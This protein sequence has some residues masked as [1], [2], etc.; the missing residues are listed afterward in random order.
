MGAVIAFHAFPKTLPGGFLGVD[1]FFVI[2]GFLISGMIL[3]AIRE[4]RFS[5][6]DFY[7][8]RARRIVPALLTMLSCITLLAA[9]VLMPDEMERFG[10]N[11]T[12]GALFVP[13]LVLAREQ[14]YFDPAAIDNPLLHLWS[15]GVEEQ[16]YL[17]WP[18]ALMLLLPRM[19]AR[20]MVFVIAAIIVLSFAL[21]AVMA[22]HAPTAAFYLPFTRFWQL[23]AGAL[24]AGLA[25][26][27]PV[28]PHE[29]GT[30]LSPMRRPAWLNHLMSFAGLALIGAAI[31]AGDVSHAQVSLALPVTVG[32]ALF[33][34]AGPDALP[35]RTLFSWRPVVYVGLISYPLYLWHWPP[36]SFLHLMELNE[37]T[38]GRILRVG[39]VLFAFAASA[40]T[41]HL[42]ELPIRRRKDLRRIGV[43]L[44][45][46]L[47]AAAVAG[48]A[49]AASGGLPQRTTLDHNPFYRTAE[50]RRE[51]RC[52]EIYGQP[53]ALLKAAFCVRN[54]YEHEPEIV[55]LGD[56]HSN[57]FV[58]GVQAVYP[59]ASTL[60]IGA[61]AC[62]YLRNTE[63]W[64]D[65]RKS[66]RQVCPPLTEVAYRA[67]GPAT[68]L[69]I[70]AARMP[71]YI[72]SPEEYAATYDYTSPKHFQSPLFPG[73]SPPETWRLA[74]MRDL[75]LLLAAD[76]EVV[77]VLPVPALDFS[78]RTC[79]R[80]RPIERWMD[81]P[82]A[83]ACSVPRAEVE[84]AHAESR[85]LIAR[86]V[87]EIADPDLHVVDPADALCDAHRCRAVIGGHLMYIDDNHLSPDGS[88]YVWE[89]IQP[90][91]LRATADRRWRTPHSAYRPAR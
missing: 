25:T 70:L 81:E 80:F 13:N 47:G 14:G 31:L 50:M 43:R 67:V 52:S 74:L 15:L 9:L 83:D 16:F 55:L 41:Y 60:Q 36:L 76:R 38:L 72:A 18:L 71:G 40:L 88:R 30:A 48:V 79:V 37:G 22:R 65:S 90:R 73:A 29:G 85:A 4:G 87:R 59:L 35:N 21:H 17:V 69:V 20:N 77:L 42:V 7:L 86:V 1:V 78:P 26:A 10:S 27:R 33:I 53:E 19:G 75:R 63:Y 61:S 12:A 5:L 28:A 84:A 3:D 11:V 44:L 24:L 54:D 32:A 8:R 62:P 46:G 82:D 49:V 91:N 57:M 89:R 64:N 6:L 51:D 23:L 39:A 2:S 45:G 66:W 58:S 34:A 68:R 56:S